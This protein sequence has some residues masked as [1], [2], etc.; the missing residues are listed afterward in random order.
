[1][2]ISGTRQINEL[3]SKKEYVSGCRIVFIILDQNLFKL[4]LGFKIAICYPGQF[5]KHMNTP[6]GGAMLS[7]LVLYFLVE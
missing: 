6:L 7:I 4:R 3:N 1:M 5:L 2:F